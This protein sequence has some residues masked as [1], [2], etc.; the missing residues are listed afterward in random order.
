MEASAGNWKH[1]VLHFP[2]IVFPGFFLGL[3]YS[4]E[5]L[6]FLS[7][8]GVTGKQERESWMKNKYLSWLFLG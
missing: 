3:C 4:D 5:H 8:T 6:Y 1:S 7:S 2:P